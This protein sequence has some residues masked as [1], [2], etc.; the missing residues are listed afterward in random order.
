MAG[1]LLL[2]LGFS[3]AAC[4]NAPALAQNNQDTRRQVE[5]RLGDVPTQL[6]TATA[7]RL[8]GAFRAAA[9]R[10]L[11]A[12]VQ[13]SVEAAP[14]TGRQS[15]P[16]APFPFPFPFPFPDEDGQRAPRVG[17]GSGFIF[18]RQGLILTNRHVVEGATRVAVTLPDGREFDA[19]VVG[20]D[21]NTDVGVIRIN[22]RGEAL[23]VAQLGNSDELQVGDWVL[24]LGNPLGLNFTVTAGIVSA[25]GRAIGILAQQQ[26]MS[27]LEA[28]IQTDAAINPGNS[29]GPL[30]DLLGRVVGINTA[31]QGDPT[32]GRF[33]GYGFAV[34]IT[35]A[36]RV[37]DD[38]VE[39]G[40]VRRPRLGVVVAP[41]EDVDVE[42]YRLPRVAG[43]EV[44]SVQEGS[45]AEAAGLRMGDV[46]VSVN[47]EPIADNTDLTTRLARMQPG[48][49]VRLGVIRY[50][51]RLEVTARLSQFETPETRTAERAQRPG[52]TELLGF[53]ART[54]TPELAREL[55]V[56]LREGVVV[57][58]LT[59]L[60]PAAGGLSRGVIVRRVNGREIR[61]MQDLE[62]VAGDLKPGDAV[63]IVAYDPQQRMDRIVNY[64]IRR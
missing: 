56:E 55:G 42:V 28:F 38:L 33:A 61:N 60:S 30:V 57:T 64:R 17:T 58:G 31:I 45:P 5:E 37:A 44:V 14:S 26:G 34:P 3:L 40:V 18:D 39:Y 24:A 11:P 51:E 53:T 16:R 48:D 54:L 15:T 9:A 62:A 23:P 49:R 22:P 43:A 47:G 19:E 36:K 12:V 1:A 41:V 10:A 52:T 59:P 2:P 63:S 7:A 8:S 46:I 27:A 25:K 21:P 4:S 13:I 35:L 6:D 50:G 20:T 32:T 29:G